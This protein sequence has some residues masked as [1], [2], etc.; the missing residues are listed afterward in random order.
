[1]ART[2]E[3][4]CHF[5]LAVSDADYTTAKELFLEYAASLG[6]DLCFQGFDKELETLTQQYGK[7]AGGILL[8]EAGEKAVGCAAVRKFDNETGELKRMYIRPAY[9]GKGQG[10]PLLHKAIALAK[11]LGYKKLRLD[12]LPTMEA[13]GKLY[14]ETGFQPI[15]PYNYNPHEGVRYFEL[16]LL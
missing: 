12:T 9:R 16:D 10:R 15:A 3:P 11:E 14:R 13:A 6:F 1:M 4:E 5:R 7:P 2:Y 8:L